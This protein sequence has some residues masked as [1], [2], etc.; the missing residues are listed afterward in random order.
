MAMPKLDSVAFSCPGGETPLSSQPRPIDLAHLS[1]QSL[2]D[3]A[4]EAEVLGLFLLQASGVRETLAG[5]A[6]AERA[7]LAHGLR[8]SAA[9]VGA[10]AVADAAKAIER[11]PDDQALIRRLSDCIDEARG[12]IASISR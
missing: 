6:P 12:F 9:G 10:F 2:G 4:I 11:K 5:L 7:R 8:G 1:R 3:R